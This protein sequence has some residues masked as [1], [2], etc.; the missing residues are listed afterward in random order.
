MYKFD[1]NK[2]RVLVVGLDIRPNII[3][4]F[5]NSIQCIFKNGNNKKLELRITDDGCLIEYDNAMC[6]LIQLKENSI[7]CI[8]KIINEFMTSRSAPS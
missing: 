7:D 4:E 3:R 6:N 5:D 8:N 2:A 1:I